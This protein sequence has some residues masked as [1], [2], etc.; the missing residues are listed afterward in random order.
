[1]FLGDKA[2]IFSCSS[3]GR[4]TVLVQ[5]EI[6]WHYWMSCHEIWCK[7]FHT[8]IMMNWTSSLFNWRHRRAPGCGNFGR[9]C[10]QKSGEWDEALDVQQARLE[11]SIKNVFFHFSL[12]CEPSHT[13]L[14]PCDRS[15]SQSSLCDWRL[16]V[17]CYITCQTFMTFFFFQN[18]YQHSSAHVAVLGES[19]ERICLWIASLKVSSICCL[20]LC[21]WSVKPIEVLCIVVGC[22]N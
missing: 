7:H 21:N 20:F 18:N 8:P 16:S 17:L 3:T 10:T 19:L 2:S 14:L 15:A 9:T 13:T 6:F 22:T 4:L 5:N 1:M 11:K 12:I